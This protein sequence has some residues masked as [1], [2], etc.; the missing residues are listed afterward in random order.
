MTTINA[1]ETRSGIRVIEIPNDELAGMGLGE[2]AIFAQALLGVVPGEPKLHESTG[3]TPDWST[4]KSLV[5]GAVKE[6]TDKADYLKHKLKGKGLH[7]LT[8]EQLLIEYASAS[9]S[10]AFA[11]METKL[12]SSQIDFFVHDDQ[13][14]V[15]KLS[16]MRASAWDAK[17]QFNPAVIN[18]DAFYG[19]YRGTTS[20]IHKGDRK[21]M[22]TM[23]RQDAHK[24]GDTISGGMQLGGHDSSA[25]RN[26]VAVA[27]QTGWNLMGASGSAKALDDR[28]TAK[29]FT[30][31]KHFNRPDAIGIGEFGEGSAAQGMV[32]NAVEDAVMNKASA[33]FICYANNGSISMSQ[34]EAIPGGDPTM[35]ARG[36]EAA[37]LLK[38]FRVEATDIAGNFD[39]AR[40]AMEYARSGKG[41]V[42]LVYDNL[43]RGTGHTSSGQLQRFTMPSELERQRKQGQMDPYKQFLIDNEV[44]TEQELNSI[45]QG[46]DLVARTEADTAMQ[47]EPEDAETIWDNTHHENRSYREYSY[48]TEAFVPPIARAESTRTRGVDYTDKSRRGKDARLLT[49]R[50]GVNIE[51]AKAM[52]K[53]PNMVIFGEDVAMASQRD[54]RRLPQYFLE[55][56][57]KSGNKFSDK[58]KAL[59]SSVVEDIMSGNGHN[60]DPVAFAIFSDIMEGKGGVFG[61]TK[62]EQ[63]A[64]GDRVFNYPIDEP[65]I[66]GA[67]MGRAIAGQLPVV[68]IQFGSYISEALGQ[69]TDMWATLRKRGKGNHVAGGVV[70]VQGGNRVGLNWNTGRVGG[71]GGPGHGDS[72]GMDYRR[73]PGLIFGYPGD[74]YDGAYMLQE[75]IRVAHE[76]GELVVLLEPIALFNTETQYYQGP[77]AHIPLLE[78]EKRR[79]GN[80]LTLVSWGSTV[81]VV[82]RVAQQL[83][84]EDGVN[85]DVINARTTGVESGHLMDMMLESL[86]RTGKLYLAEAGRDDYAEIIAQLQMA[87]FTNMDAPIV[88][89]PAKRVLMGAGDQFER[90]IV[91]QVESIKEGVRGLL[92]Y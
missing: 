75:A 41:P 85:I 66:L 9:L 51:L 46:A 32:K 39:V 3:K 49:Y 63:W 83:A 50:Q 42:M 72:R 71:V 79:S 64:F 4:Q 1:G 8:R 2:A 57:A 31:H 70:R 14:Q 53:Y 29:N 36:Y 15:A 6:R 52:K 16:W 65:R 34:D 89:H 68:E 54:W 44:A 62:Y 87:G 12:W 40:Q 38:I 74:A 60:M 33:L 20:M 45:A 26:S 28:R 5:E 7:G 35:F 58:E 23:Y 25:E 56:A 61:M 10:H 78:A 90:Y 67:A 92:A 80:D 30:G 86:G 22:Q 84:E 11:Q 24:K 19:M 59:A 21:T 43:Y 48:A 55:Q 13:M 73:Q 47:A 17:G 82:D 81:P 37:G 69:L 77:D 88:G 91:P 76:E 27:S 18:E